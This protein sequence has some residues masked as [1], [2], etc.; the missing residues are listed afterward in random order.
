M[1]LRHIDHFLAIVEGGSV[2]LAAEQVGLTQQALSKSLLRLEEQVGAPLFER[3][4][5]GMIP[6]PFGRA[7]IDQARAVQAEGRALTHL[8][9]RTLNAQQGRLVIG[10][11]PVIEGGAASAALA[12][13]ALAN[14]RLGFDI[15]Q[16]SDTT[17]I[18]ALLAGEL[19][20]AVCLAKSPV[21]PRINCQLIG[22]EEWLVVGRAGHPALA[23]ARDLS[24]LT[25]AAWM[26]GLAQDQLFDAV[27]RDFKAAGIPV[28]TTGIATNMLSFTMQVLRNSDFLFVAPRSTSQHDTALLARRLAPRPWTV[29]AVILTRKSPIMEAVIG[30]LCKVIAAAYA[31]DM[32][33]TPDA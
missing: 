8:A 7:L 22:E 29:P 18:P 26:V 3:T 9:K 12:Q 6:T 24:D 20:M 10:L 2:A 21:D 13:F 19:D 30:P 32:R 16:G 4:A 27:V 17:F 31:R 1:D 5:K 15:V 14:P 33:T 28:P 25:H 23:R 11:S